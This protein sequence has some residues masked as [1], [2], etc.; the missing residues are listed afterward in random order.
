MEEG[1]VKNQEVKE[2]SIKKITRIHII[3]IILILII[4]ILLLILIILLIYI[5]SKTENEEQNEKQESDKSPLIGIV[6]KRDPEGEI[7]MNNYDLTQIDYI[8]AVEKSGGIPISLPV[9]QNFN[10]EV[11]KRQIE[12]VDGIMIQGGFDVSPSLYNEEPKEE[13]GKT[14][15]QTDNY[16]MEVIKQA[17]NRKIPILGICRGIQILNVYFGGTLY[18]DL[19]YAQLD[20]KTHTQE[21]NTSCNYK[22]TISVEKNTYLSKMFPYNDTLY[23]NSFH[24]QAI[25]KLGKDLIVEARSEDGIIEAFH[26]NDESQWIFGVQFHPE[27]HVICNNDFLPIFSELVK[28]AK[29]SRNK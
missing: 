19:K 15:I 1:L 12:A 13:L 21:Y 16:I 10:T 26:K 20:S 6:V 27:Q 3:I 24:H 9:L 14:D 5:Y 22:H 23:V 2:E 25:N 17:I 7:S 28:Q 29:K 18:Q 4:F 11:I 8:G